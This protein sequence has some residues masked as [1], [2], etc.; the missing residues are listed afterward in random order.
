M[1]EK[2]AVS[3][4]TAGGSPARAAGR[5]RCGAEVRG[6]ALRPRAG[7]PRWSPRSR[8]GRADEAICGPLQTSQPTGFLSVLSLFTGIRKCSVS[9]GIAQAR[10]GLTR[11]ERVWWIEDKTGV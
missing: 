7:G 10:G 1:F 4:A 3:A 2:E 9:G 11:Q 8:V 5:F 6:P